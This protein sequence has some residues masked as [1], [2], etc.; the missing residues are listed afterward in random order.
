MTQKTIKKF[1]N[2]TYSK[3]P[4]ENFSTNETDV[5]YIDKI[6]NLDVLDL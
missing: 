1:L 3:T 5:Y 4:K 2:E 6:W